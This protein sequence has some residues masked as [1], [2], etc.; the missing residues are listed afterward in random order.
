MCDFYFTFDVS[1]VPQPNL[2]HLQVATALANAGP[3]Q[4]K[5]I[6]REIS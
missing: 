4:L 6:N 1:M 5:R 2:I 3:L